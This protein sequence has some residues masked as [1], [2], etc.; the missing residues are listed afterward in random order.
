MLQKKNNI[1][2]HNIF[3]SLTNQIPIE[4][5]SSSK[6]PIIDFHDTPLRC[7][8]LNFATNSQDHFTHM[9]GLRPNIRVRTEAESLY[10]LPHPEKLEWDSKTRPAIPAKYPRFNDVKC[11]IRIVQLTRSTNNSLARCTSTLNLSKSLLLRNISYI[12]A[13]LNQPSLTW[14]SN[15]IFIVYITGTNNR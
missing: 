7:T 12:L 10:V 14:G 3:T 8:N 1:E 15:I 2:F 5:D 11:H 4:D 9:I 13:L 6:S